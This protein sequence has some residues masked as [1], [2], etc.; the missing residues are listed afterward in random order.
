MLNPL[1]ADKWNFTT[2]AHLLNRAGFGGPPSEIEHLAELGPERAVAQLVDFEK[3][4]DDT[5]DPEWAKPDPEKVKRFQA[6]RQ[7]GEEERRRL[8]RDEQQMQRQHIT[9]LRG[10]W[11]QR[12][13]K[14]PRPLQEK[15]TLFWHGHF[16]TSTEKVREAY[17]MWRQNELFRRLAAG[18]WP[19]LL[20]EVGKDP[21]MLIYL[22]Q[23]QSANSTRTKTSPV[24]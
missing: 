4:P 21:A 17:L 9:E 7:A 2:A 15:L 1:S 23:A 14:G 8:Q 13:A 5:A 18:N 3:I 12:M 20:I 11:L 19:E 24:K 6:M 10:W 22:D 16:A